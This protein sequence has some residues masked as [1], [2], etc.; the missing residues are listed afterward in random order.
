MKVST[1]V[2]LLIYSQIV[3]ANFFV[4]LKNPAT[5]EQLLANDDKVT[6]SSHH[7]RGL[8]EN[9][10][11]FG[12]F[13]GFSGHFHR[14]VIKRLLKSPMVLN[15]VR[16]VPIK[17]FDHENLDDTTHYN[18]SDE[19][20]ETEPHDNSGYQSTEFETQF[21]APRHLARLSRR[22]TLP[23]NESVNYYYDPRFLGQD[24]NA[25]IIDTGIHSE[26]PDFEGRVILSKDFTMFR[27]RGDQSGHG[28]HVA[29]LVGSKTF[30]VAKKVNLIDLK[31]LGS[32]GEGTLSTVLSALQ[33]AVTHRQES[34]A[35]GVVNLSLGSFRND[36]LNSAIDNAV[37]SGLVIVVAAGNFG[38]D[39]CLSSPASAS[40]AI[41]VGA[42]DDRNDKIA[43]FSNWGQCVHVF[44][45]GIG[46]HSVSHVSETQ[47]MELSG[48]SMSSP[49]IAGLAAVLLSKGIEPNDIKSLII[50]MSTHGSIIGSINGSPNH[51]A[52]NGVYKSDDT[53]PEDAFWSEDTHGPVFQPLYKSAMVPSLNSQEYAQKDIDGWA[54]Y[55]SQINPS[56]MS[57]LFG[58]EEDE[59][60]EGDETKFY[61]E[62]V[63][64]DFNLQVESLVNEDGDL[65]LL[66]D[67]EYVSKE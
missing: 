55:L 19:A 42:I 16:D 1:F 17:V 25:Y 4:Q 43:K 56:A 20:I 52:Y 62:D 54:R 14:D 23:Y 49:V 35:K 44:G 3:Y 38:S 40:R 63:H 31:A 39:S 13:T 22:S 45:S 64:T 51:I 9:V 36:V 32:H 5:L 47:S 37:E 50:E 27:N 15:I 46:V 58:A 2:Q 30:G 8:V 61:D 21:M 34:G 24:V 65:A 6:A 48:T 53:F 29:G 66:Y 60:D 33:F 28:T 41:S 12:N 18:Y 11:S 26:H 67:D 57:V 10:I 7:I 59:D